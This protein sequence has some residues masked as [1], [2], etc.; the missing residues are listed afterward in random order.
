MSHHKTPEYEYSDDYMLPEY[1]FSGKTGVR[2]KYYEILR[3]GYTIK[4][5]REDGS[6]LVQHIT[7]K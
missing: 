4:I 3:E 2:S 5:H 1:D 6:T 7:D